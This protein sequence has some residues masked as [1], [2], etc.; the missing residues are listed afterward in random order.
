MSEKLP[1]IICEICGMAHSTGEHEFLVKPELS[2]DAKLSSETEPNQ[3]AK[4]KIVDIFKVEDLKYKN[5]DTNNVPSILAMG[6]LTPIANF[7]YEPLSQVDFSVRGKIRA[8]R[9]ERENER[10][11]KKTG[12]RQRF[13]DMGNVY[14]PEGALQY[15]RDSFLENGQIEVYDDRAETD[16]RRQV[17]AQF[18]TILTALKLNREF[19]QFYGPVQGEID[20]TLDNLSSASYGPLRI[21]DVKEHKGLWKKTHDSEDAKTFR[22]FITNPK[23]WELIRI[24]CIRYFF[25]DGRDEKGSGLWQ[26]RDGHK[27]EFGFILAPETKTVLSYDDDYPSQAT[28]WESR[29][30]PD[31]ILG[32]IINPEYNKE[33]R[34]PYFVPHDALSTLTRTKFQIPED[35]VGFLTFYAKRPFSFYL[36]EHGYSDEKITELYKIKPSEFKNAVGEEE[37]QRLEELAKSFFKKHSPIQE[38]ETLMTGLIHIAEQHQLP[39]YTTRGELLWPKNMKHNELEEFIKNKSQAR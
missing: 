24:E 33:G 31:K 25:G 19:Q 6:V 30:R 10:Q 21:E 18:Y 13:A 26:R 29:V 34:P 23:I 38:G 11:G 2:T 17:V 36:K 28:L 9:D 5:V 20:K 35:L 1:T 8:M 12:N 39:I 3:E 14:Y 7:L 4:Q 27:L 32:F 37:Y 15:L 22:D 16:I